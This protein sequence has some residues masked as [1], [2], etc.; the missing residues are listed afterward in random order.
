MSLVCTAASIV[1][2]WMAAGL[3]IALVLGEI[4]RGSKR[5]GKD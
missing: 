4:L 3:L 2:G 1:V 5:N